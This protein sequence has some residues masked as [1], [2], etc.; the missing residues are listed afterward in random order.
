MTVQLYWVAAVQLGSTHYKVIAVIFRAVII[1]KTGRIIVIK[2]KKKSY[3]KRKINTTNL[4]HDL[5]QAFPQ[6]SIR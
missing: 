5:L 3:F 2:K 6:T 1:L 4:K